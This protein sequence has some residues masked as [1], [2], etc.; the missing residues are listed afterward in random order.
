MIKR[1]FNW[2]KLFFTMSSDMGKEVNITYPVCWEKMSS[3]DFETVCRIISSEQKRSEPE[4]LFLLLCSLAKMRPDN[5]SYDP[6]A[7]KD[8]VVFKIGS[9]CYVISPKV[10]QA[11]CSDLGFILHSIGLSPS[12]FRMVDR[13]LYGITFGQYY[14]AD[15]MIMRYNDTQDSIYLEQAAAILNRHKVNMPVWRQKA[16]IIWWNGIKKY[17]LE[18][19]P[20]IF[21]EGDSYEAVEKSPAD[22]LQELLSAM[23]SD[24]PQDNDKILNTELHSVL[25]SLNNIYRKNAHK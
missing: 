16:L 1:L 4:L 23:N 9:K 6:D 13:K 17:L 21:Q 11:G 12:P 24:R 22:I 14:E 25:Y 15:A 7:L 20:Y 10:I 2:I 18:K 19:Y 5:I 3:E 8:N